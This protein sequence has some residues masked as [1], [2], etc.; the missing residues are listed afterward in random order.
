M[1][2]TFEEPSQWRSIDGTNI[3]NEVVPSEVSTY[4]P[5]VNGMV[6]FT[7]VL[8]SL[9]P[10]GKKYGHIQ[11][12]ITFHIENGLIISTHCDNKELETDLLNIFNYCPGNREIVI[13]NWNQSCYK[14]LISAPF[15]ERR[16]SLG[17]GGY[18]PNTQHIDF[19]F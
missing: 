17:T 19:V 6:V 8:V 13:R 15:E 5:N 1:E 18:Q 11:H 16:V 9:V 3:A 10:I 2:F 14:L 12:P 4:T 7:G